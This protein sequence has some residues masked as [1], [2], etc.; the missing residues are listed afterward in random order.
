[1]R[2]REIREDHGAQQSR[3]SRLEFGNL[4]P[5]EDIEEMKVKFRQSNVESSEG[6]GTVSARKVR[7]LTSGR[8]F[9]RRGGQNVRHVHVSFCKE[10]F[11]AFM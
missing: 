10:V 11:D 1:M 4:A 6:Q 8:S 5:G 9:M 3:H 2:A 7:F